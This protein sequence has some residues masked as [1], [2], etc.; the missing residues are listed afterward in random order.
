MFAL[1]R[2]AKIRDGRTP[3][4]LVT[5]FRGPSPNRVS[6]YS[7]YCTSRFAIH[8]L[9]GGGGGEGGLVYPSLNW[10]MWLST[11]HDHMSMEVLQLS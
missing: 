9:A 6:T 10:I 1:C 11:Q 8:E 2:L 5:E 7:M 3:R 4:H